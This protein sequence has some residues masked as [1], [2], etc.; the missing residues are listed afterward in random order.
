MIKTVVSSATTFDVVSLPWDPNQV[1]RLDK[2]AR[3][4]GGSPTQAH[5]NLPPSP[6]DSIRAIALRKVLARYSENAVTN[7][8]G[9][10]SQLASVADV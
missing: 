2:D 7:D 8:K 5:E 1:I 3:R 10:F 9:V 6:I 4:H